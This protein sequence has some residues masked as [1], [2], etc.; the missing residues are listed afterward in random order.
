METL[1][2]GK[3]INSTFQSKFSVRKIAKYIINLVLIRNFARKTFEHA[4]F[5]SEI[6]KVPLDY[7]NGIKNLWIAIRSNRFGMNAYKFH[8]YAQSVKK[9]YFDN[10]LEWYPMCVHIHRTIGWFLWL[11]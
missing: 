6:T 11:T 5:V 3:K 10:G 9:I 1:K 4:K 7:I 8:K 2:T